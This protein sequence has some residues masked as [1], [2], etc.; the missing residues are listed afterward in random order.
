MFRRHIIA[1]IVVSTLALSGCASGSAGEPKEVL[2]NASYPAFAT[3]VDLDKAADLVIKGTIVSSVVTELNIVIA[4]TGKEADDPR[5]NP[6]GPVDGSPL[7]VYT[8]HTVRV[9]Q[10][11][12]G[13]A[14]VGSTIEV[15]ELGGTLGETK[16][17]TTEGIALNDGASYVMYLATYPTSPAV[18]LN[19]IQA[20]YPLVNGQPSAL[21]GNTL[22]VNDIGRG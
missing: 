20:A 11:L 18:L 5:L 21:P 6:G 8:V 9:T 1:A 2:Y 3:V 7:V 13:K 22:S 16:Y 10:M 12:K 15:K 4:P 17:R 19:P 14:T